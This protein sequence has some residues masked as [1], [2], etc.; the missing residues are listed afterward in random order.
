MS[1]ISALCL[2]ALIAS[3]CDRRKEPA[4]APKRP[5]ESGFRLTQPSQAVLVAR[6][7]AEQAAHRAGEGRRAE[8]V[9][10]A[11]ESAG[12]K[13]VQPQQYLGTSVAATYCIGGRTGA[14][15]AVAVCEYPDEASARSGRETLLGKF[16]GSATRDVRLHGTLTMT[17]TGKNVAEKERAVAAFERA[18]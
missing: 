11:L 13:I 3:A 17:L 8:A 2:V 15:L 18:P 7:G 4:P 10:A 16:K 6:L 14:G 12:V 9:L 5:A 1:G